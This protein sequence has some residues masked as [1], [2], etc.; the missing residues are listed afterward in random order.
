MLALPKVSP[1]N[2]YKE[3]YKNVGI[4]FSV[5]KMALSG[6]YIPFGVFRLYGDS[7][8]QDALAMFI[9]LFMYIPEEDFQVSLFQLFCA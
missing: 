4:V 8:L 6:A 9:K 3:R 5:L 1:E 2:A 7:C